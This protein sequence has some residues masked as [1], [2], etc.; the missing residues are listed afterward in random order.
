MK[1]MSALCTRAIRVR[2]YHAVNIFVNEVQ[3]N[4]HSNSSDSYIVLIQVP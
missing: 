1:C 3:Y 2:W 4:F